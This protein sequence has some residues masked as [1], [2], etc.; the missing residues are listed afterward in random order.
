LFTPITHD[1]WPAKVG[2]EIKGLI[3]L[4]KSKK[5]FESTNN[6]KV[7]VHV[8]EDN[9][10]Q[11]IPL[12]VFCAMKSGSYYITELVEDNFDELF[13]YIR[14]QAFKFTSLLAD[15]A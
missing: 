15:K 2:E 10:L 4:Q 9:N 11:F 3:S 1:K 12:T 14:F 13:R 5:I 6:L 8:C 7:L